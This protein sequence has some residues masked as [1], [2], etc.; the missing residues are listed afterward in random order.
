[1]RM[2]RSVLLTVQHRHRKPCPVAAAHRIGGR[3]VCLFR[4]R[5]CFAPIGPREKTNRISTTSSFDKPPPRHPRFD[6]PLHVRNVRVR[7]LLVV[8]PCAMSSCATPPGRDSVR[9]RRDGTTT[10]ARSRPVVWFLRMRE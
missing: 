2:A 8:H 4:A 6:K 10:G 3:Q 7:T 5:S 9:H 1:M